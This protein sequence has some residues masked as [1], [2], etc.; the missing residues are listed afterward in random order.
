MMMLYNTENGL[1]LWRSLMALTVR[2]TIRILVLVIL[3]TAPSVTADETELPTVIGNY[4]VVRA[5]IH[6]CPSFPVLLA[7]E[8]GYVQTQ[9][10]I[11]A[12]SQFEY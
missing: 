11:L 1:N 9:K 5:T 7:S 4:V 10:S 3:M 6:D 2:Y 12:V 8:K